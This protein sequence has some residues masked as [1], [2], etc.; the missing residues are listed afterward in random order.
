M[1]PPV[2]QLAR[3]KSIDAVAQ[4]MDTV[5]VEIQPEAGLEDSYKLYVQVNGVCLLRICKLHP[6]Q[7]IQSGCVIRKMKAT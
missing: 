5:Q 2:P 3:L 4:A 6:S 7:I 1:R